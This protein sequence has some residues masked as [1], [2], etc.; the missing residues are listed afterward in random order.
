[1]IYV[2]V[3]LTFCINWS[4]VSCNFK[5]MLS[6][7]TR[8]LC[9]SVKWPRIL[10]SER[11]SWEQCKTIAYIYKSI[12]QI[13]MLLRYYFRVYNKHKFWIFFHWLCSLTKRVSQWCF[14]WVCWLC[15]GTAGRS[16]NPISTRGTDYAHLITTGKPDYQTFRRPNFQ[17]ICYLMVC[18]VL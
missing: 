6:F 3:M 11:M 5:V 10:V 18:P 8:L 7:R 9:R 15:H 16:G 1:M 4:L 14:P 2:C 12:P 17:N 13:L